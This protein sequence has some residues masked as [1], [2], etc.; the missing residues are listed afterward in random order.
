M[1]NDAI[2][3][4]MDKDAEKAVLGSMMTEKSIV[5]RIEALL[6]SSA[7]AFYTTDHKLIYSAILAVYSR[8]SKVDPLLVA[9]ELKNTDQLNRV[10]GPE[11]LYELQAPIVETENTE[12]YAGILK[13][14]ATRR[15]LI[16][17]ANQIKELAH[18][19]NVDI[20]DI[21]D[22]SQEVVFELGKTGIKR[23]FEHVRSLIKQAIGRIEVLWKQ[24]HQFLGLPTGFTHFD[25]LTAG[26]QPGNLIIIAARPGMGKTTL[27]LN[28]AQNIAIE[29]KKPVAI[30]SLEMSAEDVVMRM[31]SA[32]SR[33]DFGRLRLGH[34]GEDYWAP[35]VQSASR[36]SEAPLLINDNRAM[37][38]QALCA[39]ARRLKGE[40]ENLSMIIVDYLQLLRGA[41]RYNVREQEISEISRALKILAWELN[42]PVIACSQLNREVDRRPN[43]QPQ[44]SDLRESGAIEQDADIVAFLFREDYYDDED[45]YADETVESSLSIKKH[46]NGPPGSI[47]LHYCKKQMRFESVS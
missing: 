14:K 43:K 47:V 40:H 24:D 5:P 25:D 38:V 20:N 42:V 2:E 31:L 27:V 29:Q 32:E 34:F 41:G 23:G 8:D 11:Y 46:R 1:H 44:L 13:E 26:L 21:L 7:D 39:E 35:L 12:L 30:F 6:G 3:N 10:G 17:A 19:E 28:M 33:M 4:I 15:H 16:Q 45:D 36:I 37:T 22:Q 9:N 18:D